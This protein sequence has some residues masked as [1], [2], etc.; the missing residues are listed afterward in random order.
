MADLNHPAGL[1]EFPRPPIGAFGDFRGD[2]NAR[3]T[4]NHPETGIFGASPRRMVCASCGA[5]A[6]MDPAWQALCPSCWW[7]LVNRWRA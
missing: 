4:P 2:G 7:A 5:A 6:P 1:P 3:K